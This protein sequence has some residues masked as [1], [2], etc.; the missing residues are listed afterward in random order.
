MIANA[1]DVLTLTARPYEHRTRGKP[2]S[3]AVQP[4]YPVCGTPTTKTR[5]WGQDT[6]TVRDFTDDTPRDSTDNT[7]GDPAI[8]RVGGESLP[9]GPDGKTV[10]S[11]GS[12]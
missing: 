3:D 6:S 9:Y 5:Q 12:S 2:P 1:I 7:T 4:V 11:W 8:V 10:V